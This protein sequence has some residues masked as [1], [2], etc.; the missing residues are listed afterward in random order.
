[1]TKHEYIN[2]FQHLFSLKTDN[3]NLLRNEN[4]WRHLNISCFNEYYDN[5]CTESFPQINIVH[6]NQMLIKQNTHCKTTHIFLID[7]YICIYVTYKVAL[8]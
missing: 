2:L 7:R 1:M 5:V 6:I 3:T 4:K 8:N